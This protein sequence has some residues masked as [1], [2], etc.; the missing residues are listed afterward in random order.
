MQVSGL[1]T[2]PMPDNPTPLGRHRPS[3]ARAVLV[4][5]RVDDPIEQCAGR[6]IVSAALWP[7]RSGGSARSASPLLSTLRSICCPNAMTSRPH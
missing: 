2:T 5:E 4:D 6:S 1:A 7:K 3:T